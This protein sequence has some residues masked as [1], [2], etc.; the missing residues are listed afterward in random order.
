M[1]QFGRPSADTNNDGAWVDEAAGSVNLWDGID[2]VTA[3]DVLFI[4]SVSAP[5]SAPYVAALQ[6]ITLEDPVSSSGHIVRYRY[7][8]NAAGG[9]QIDLT[10]QLRQGYVSEASQGTLI[11][12][13]A[14]NNISNG[15]VSGSFTLLAGEADSITD[16]TSLYLRIVANQV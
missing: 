1:A 3:E 14:V 2:E 4:E 8:K 11:R 13:E 9:A 6:D 10:I 5:S 7:Q 12:S 15:F 16:Y